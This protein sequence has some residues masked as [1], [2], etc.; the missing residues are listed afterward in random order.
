MEK[1][2]KFNFITESYLSDF[3][4]KVTISMLGNYLL[5]AA[6]SHAGERGFGYSDMNER[7]AA[8]VLSRLAIEMIDY[9]KMAEPI[10][11]YTWIEEVGRLFTMRCF[12]L[13]GSDGKPFGYARSIWAAIDL[14]SR[15]PTPLDVEALSAYISDRPCPIEKPGKILPVENAIKTT[16]FCV[17]YSDLDINKHLNSMK[18]IEYLLDMFNIEMFEEKDIARF[19]ISYI[20]EGR[21]GMD[22][23]LNMEELDSDKYR[24]SIDHEGTAICRASV[25]W[26]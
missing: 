10:T 17:K 26:K 19:E 11:L 22:M 16:S 21:Y 25:K 24:M 14:K 9:P 7:Q 15:R 18:S 20:Q 12:E 23:T 8:W 4:G 6:S 5:H 3:R 2:G 1:E 13:Q